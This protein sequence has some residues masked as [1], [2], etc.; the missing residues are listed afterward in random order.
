MNPEVIADRTFAKPTFLALVL[1]VSVAAIVLFPLFTVFYQYPRLEEMVR[2]FARNQAVGAAKELVTVLVP[3]DRVLGRG[4]LTPQAAERLERLE[5]DGL[6][7]KLRIHSPEGEILY[8]S[9][10]REIGELNR[11]PY[12][13]DILASRRI[14]ARELPRDRRLPERELAPAG[15]VET[16]VPIVRGG[17]LLGVFEIHYDIGPEKQKLRSLFGVSS[18]VLLSLAAVLLAAV[19]VSVSHARQ[20]LQDRERVLEELRTLSISDDLTGLY[21]RRGFYVLAE[22]QIKIARR[23]GRAMLLASADLDGLKSINDGFGHHEGDRALVDAAQILRD[24]FRESDIIGRIGGDEFVVLM[25]EKPELNARVLFDRLA[26]KLEAH[27]R[28]VTRPYPFSISLG[29]ASFDP[30]QPVSLNDLLVQA[31]RSMY[32][33]KV[34]K[35]HGT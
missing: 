13:Q 29:I 3:D 18:G 24:S 33:A 35:E 16:H 31:D 9:D 25:T 12:F 26:R 7:V 17:R 8:S 6:F 10:A 14:A 15:V 20:Y 27:N 1:V 23:T 11:D 32:E 5:R 34:R 2:D 30:K 21:N 19:L 4:V 28:K 22:Q